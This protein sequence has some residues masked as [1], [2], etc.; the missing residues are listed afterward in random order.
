M[1]TYAQQQSQK[2]WIL[3]EFSSLGFI[4]NAKIWLLHFVL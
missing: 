4:G 2:D 1:K 3:L